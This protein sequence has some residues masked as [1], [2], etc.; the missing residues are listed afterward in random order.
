V[1]RIVSLGFLWA[2]VM[3]VM[4]GCGGRTLAGSEGDAGRAHTVDDPRNDDGDGA[5]E[6][7][8]QAA[9][10]AGRQDDG[11]PDLEMEF[12]VCPPSPPPADADCDPPGQ[13]CAYYGFSSCQSWICSSHGW[14]PGGQ[15]C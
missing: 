8:A 12:F 5:A 10:D 2:N 11:A 6:N 15:G 1:R 3:A 13:V 9:D 14:Q 4:A 7:T